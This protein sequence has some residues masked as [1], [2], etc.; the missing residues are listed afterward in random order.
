MRRGD[1]AVADATLV[2]KGGTADDVETATTD[3]DGEATVTVD[4]SLGPNQEDGT[5]VVEVKPPA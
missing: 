2:V 5:L 3:A 4:P 1:E